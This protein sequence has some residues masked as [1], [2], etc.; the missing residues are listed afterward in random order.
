MMQQKR[1]STKRKVFLSDD[2]DEEQ[3]TTE[4]VPLPVTTIAEIENEPIRRS[5]AKREMS[6][7]KHSRR[8]DAINE[9]QVCLFLCGD[10]YRVY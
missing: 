5:A 3:Q 2:E 9:F 8:V 4:S 10:V 7:K 1:S 6:S